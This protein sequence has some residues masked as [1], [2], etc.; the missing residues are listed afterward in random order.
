LW[1]R[2]DELVAAALLLLVGGLGVVWL[3]RARVDHHVVACADNLRQFHQALSAYAD[4]NHDQFPAV[5]AEHPKNFAGSF[6]AA[7]N[8]AR[9]MPAGLSV[10]CPGDPPQ[11]PSAVTFDALARLNADDFQSVTRSLAGCYAYSLGYLE[12]GGG[13]LFGLTRSMDGRLPIMA[14]APAGDGPYEVRPGNS[15]NHEGKGQN[16]LFIDGHVEFRPTRSVALDDDIYLNTAGRVAA[17]RGSRD[18]VLG[19]SDAR[20]FPE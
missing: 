15:A 17:G 19:R 8:E 2:V 12:P 5:G 3:A 10:G 4:N 6:V 9:V 7:L 20:P 18:T 14:D 1:R 11:P 13:G 16:V